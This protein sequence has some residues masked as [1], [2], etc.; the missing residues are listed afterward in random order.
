MTHHSGSIT[1]CGLVP[2]CTQVVSQ[3]PCKG[4]PIQGRH[5]VH[6]RALTT[7]PPDEP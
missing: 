6:V 7:L 3:E 2:A 4:Y 1:N 5:C